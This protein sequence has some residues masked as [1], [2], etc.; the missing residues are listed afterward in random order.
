MGGAIR[1]CSEKELDAE[2][3]LA[4]YQDAGW[5]AYTDEPERLRRAVANSTHVVTAW[6]GDSLVGLARVISDGEHIV[7]A[8]DLLV[9]REYR[10]RGLGSALLRRVLEPFAH[11]R[12]TVLLTDNNPEMQAFYRSL[13]FQMARRSGIAAF[14]RL[15]ARTPTR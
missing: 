10:R 15:R 2:Q 14:L 9:R 1:F 3:L 6:D 11:V 12:Q 5:T 4:L 7:Y 8:Q 13:G